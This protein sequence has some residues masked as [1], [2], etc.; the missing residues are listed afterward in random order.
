MLNVIIVEMSQHITCV[1]RGV[2]Q[3][4]REGVLLLGGGAG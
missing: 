1:L 2:R 3:H 4:V